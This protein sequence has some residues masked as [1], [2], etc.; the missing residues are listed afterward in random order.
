[1]KSNVFPESKEKKFIRDRIFTN[2]I[3]P[4]S[5]NIDKSLVYFGL[6]SASMRDV[7][8]WKSTLEKV[9]AVE[10]NQEVAKKIY[11]IA[12]KIQIRKRLILFE[13]E[14]NRVLYMLSLE[15]SLFNSE[16][17][18]L[19][20]HTQDKFS[21]IRK[22]P[23]RVVNLDY[24]GGFLY[25][26]D[27]GSNKHSK[28]LDYLSK[29]QAKFGEPFL[30]FLTFQIRDDG[31]DHYDHFIEE[32]INAMENSGGIRSPSIVPYFTE[33]DFSEV[34]MH[35]RRMKFCIPVFILKLFY[36]D[37]DV[38]INNIYKYKS[39]LFFSIRMDP[40][41]ES[42]ALGRWPPVEDIHRIVSEDVLSLSSPEGGG[43]IETDY[44]PHT[45]S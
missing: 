37:Y 20:S 27:D 10:R 17:S 8:K 15:D 24:F 19:P 38:S 34:S 39:F 18:G 14:V 23:F 4:L 33:S 3:I 29:H 22:T 44:I 28:S 30:L 32:T 2:D 25:P 35:L 7:K 16:V 40:R 9:V 11:R 6:P 5:E 21:I 42:G 31:A 41:P 26:S 12:T 43:G 1:M 45:D 13:M 36:E